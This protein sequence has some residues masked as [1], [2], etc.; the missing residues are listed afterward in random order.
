[1]IA[2]LS[3]VAW[4][5]LN[6]PS[7]PEIAVTSSVKSTASN[8]SEDQ[9]AAVRDLKSMLDKK[10]QGPLI[11]VKKAAPAR[12]ET[13]VKTP[14]NRWPPVTVDCIFSGPNSRLAVISSQQ[15]TYT[16]GKGEGFLG[17]IVEEVTA[18]GVSLSLRGETRDFEVIQESNVGA[19][20]EK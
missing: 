19:S 20:N 9:Y 14:V 6:P 18:D 11:P 12:T 10:L 4:S 3:V 1:M 7:S 17:L 15:Q 2:G 5:F 8:A 16:C 13:V